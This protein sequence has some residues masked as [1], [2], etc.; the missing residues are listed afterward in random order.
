MGTMTAKEN[1]PILWTGHYAEDGTLVTD[2]SEP[3]SKNL[4]RAK[5]GRREEVARFKRAPFPLYGLP[6]TWLGARR[7]GGGE[8]GTSPTLHRETIHALS[9]V[10]GSNI[11]RQGPSLAV[12]TA[13]P[14]PSRGGGALRCIAGQLWFG[15]AS[16]VDEAQE[17]DRG[18][19]G[20][21]EEGSFAEL[22]R[23]EVVLRIEGRAIPFDS[24]WEDAGW[25]SYAEVDSYHITVEGYDFDPREVDL[26]RITDLAPYIEGGH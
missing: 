2:W 10:H 14:D 15:D 24:L 3:L 25:V 13:A 16:T 9:L 4:R 1:E 23:R 17:A 22:V 26:L 7:L 19:G 18:F 6:P 11:H 5:R 12:E 21:D 20:D 8:W